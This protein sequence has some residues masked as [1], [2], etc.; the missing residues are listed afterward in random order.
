MVKPRNPQFS[1]YVNKK[2]HD[3]EIGYSYEPDYGMCKLTKTKFTKMWKDMIQ[4][5]NE[6]EAQRKYKISQINFGE[7]YRNIDRDIKGFCT[8]HDYFVFFESS[9]CE[10]LPVSTEEITYLFKRHDKGRQGRVTEA[11]LHKELV[12]MHEFAR[13]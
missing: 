13:R 6:L 9:Y 11:D 1:D 3:A 4:L 10:D 7:L 12:S 8:L 2:L 5:E